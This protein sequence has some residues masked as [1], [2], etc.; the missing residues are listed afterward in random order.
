MRRTLT[1]LD[2]LVAVAVLCNGLGQYH[3][4]H[5]VKSLVCDRCHFLIGAILYGVLDKDF[6]GA[7][8]Q[9]FRLGQVG[10][11][12]LFGQDV[13]AGKVLASLLPQIG[14]I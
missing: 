2:P 9:G 1:V 14:E 7:E 13:A 11:A 8:A 12:E 10:L 3:C 4:S 5:L 6:H